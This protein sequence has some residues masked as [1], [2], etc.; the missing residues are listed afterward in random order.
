MA[1]NQNRAR[2][3]LNTAPMWKKVTVVLAAPVAMLVVI[4]VLHANTWNVYLFLVVLIGVAV[5][6]VWGMA[7][8][9][10][11]HLSLGSWD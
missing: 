11:V 2:T 6:A 5:L 7:K 9:L 1:R 3:R 4:R 8:L 10:G